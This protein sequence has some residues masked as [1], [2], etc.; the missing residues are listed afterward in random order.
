MM[1]FLGAVVCGALSAMGVGGGTLLLLFMTGLMEVPQLT[2]QYIN[3]LYFI[4]TAAAG[5]ALH[6][7]NGYVDKR[8]F[9]WC[10]AGGVAGALAGSVLAT[11]LDAG[12]LRGYF[13]WMLLLLGLW[14][15][16]EKKKTR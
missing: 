7:K 6:I 12:R 13:H 14:Q 16:L 11:G 9:G 10:A 2:A 15:L 4:P 1:R 5:V 8:S 3:L